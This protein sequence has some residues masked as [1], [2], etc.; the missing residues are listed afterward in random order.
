MIP[1][2]LGFRWLIPLRV[3]YVTHFFQADEYDFRV[4][5]LQLWHIMVLERSETPLAMSR[6]LILRMLAGEAHLLG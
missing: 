4:E 2:R 6:S 1:Y 3:Q 5:C